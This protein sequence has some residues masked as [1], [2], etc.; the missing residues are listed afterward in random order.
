MSKEANPVL[1]W[2]GG[3]AYVQTKAGNPV[4]GQSP[5]AALDQAGVRGPLT[6]ALSRRAIFVKQLPLPVTGKSELRLIVEGQISK[7]F[8]LDGAVAFDTVA[9]DVTTGEGRMTAVYAAPG[10]TIEAIRD[11]LRGWSIEA[12]VPEAL[13][14]VGIAQAAQLNDAIVVEPIPG[15]FG[16]D[17]IHH[18]VLI[19]SRAPLRQP[20][21]SVI[22]EEVELTLAAVGI[23]GLPVIAAGGLRYEHAKQATSTSAAQVLA[24]QIPHGVHLQLTEDLLAK[25]KKASASRSRLAGLLALATICAGGLSYL[26]RSDAQA[27][28]DAKETVWRAKLS[29]LR[30]EQQRVEAEAL[31]V[32]ALAKRTK[33]MISPAQPV[34][35]ILTHLSNLVPEDAWVVGLNFDRGRPIQIRG[36]ALNEAAITAYMDALN[37]SDRLKDAFLVS[38]SRTEIDNRPLVNFTVTLRAV[39]NVSVEPLKSKTTKKAVTK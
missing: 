6:V 37:H 36:A 21:T 17:V 10:T 22:S 31:K 28:I 35:D 1:V 19:Y 14:S 39:G 4:V 2:N 30:R 18:G 16:I 13:G 33:Q 3:S 9:T 7:L 29:R 15:G 5:E 32:G 38:T 23:E 27:A 24:N 11:A 20:T 26:D 25:A 12:V 8:P 34:A